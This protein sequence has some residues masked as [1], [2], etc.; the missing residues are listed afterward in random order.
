MPLLPLESIQ[1]AAQHMREYHFRT[2]LSETL[3]LEG[4]LDFNQNRQ[5]VEIALGGGTLPRAQIYWLNRKG[6]GRKFGH[7][8]WIDLPGDPYPDFYSQVLDILLQIGEIEAQQEGDFWLVRLENLGIPVLQDP[9][10]VWERITASA[11]QI[12][13]EK[14]VERSVDILSHMEMHLEVLIS[15]ESHMIQRIIFDLHGPDLHKRLATTFGASEGL[16][17]HPRRDKKKM[18]PGDFRASMLLMDIPDIGGWSEATHSLW[19]QK[20]INLIENND[21]EGIY[22]EIYNKHF[23]TDE[24]K[25]GDTFDH[26]RHHPLV[27]GTIYE[28][29]TGP[30]PPFY[31]IWFGRDAHFLAN[32]NYYW[33]YT[34]YGR[35]YNHF[36]GEDLGLEHQWYFVFDSDSPDT[37]MPGDRYYSARDWAFG[38]PPSS[39]DPRPNGLNFREAIN[40]YSLEDPFAA[41]RAWLIMGHVLHLLQDQGQPDHAMLVAHP[42]SSKSE[43]DAYKKYHY[44]EILAV[45]AAAAACAACSL[46]CLGCMAGVG[47]SVEAGCWASASDTEWG[48]EKLIAEEGY[49][50][51][52]EPLR[53]S[54]V[55]RY[56]NF[57]A[58]FKAVADYAIQAHTDSGL[59]SAL[60]CGWLA[61]LPPIPNADPDIDSEDDTETAPYLALTD[62]VAVNTISTCAGFL[63]EFCEII[64]RPPIVERVAVMQWEPRATPEEFAAFPGAQDYCLFYEAHWE[65]AGKKRTLQTGKNHPLSL[66]RPAY[67]FVMFS[68]GWKN[69]HGGRRMREV[70]LNLKGIYPGT[71]QVMDHEVELTE[72]KDSNLGFFYWGS[73]EPFNCSKEEYSLQMVFEGRDQGGHLMR[74]VHP[75]D[76]LDSDPSTIAYPH[77]QIFPDH[78][79]MNYS[80]GSDRNHLIKISPPELTEG[81]SPAGQMVLK[82]EPQLH[83]GRPGEDPVHPVRAEVTLSLAQKMWDCHQEHYMGPPMC[84]ITW[85]LASQI[86]KVSRIS[87]QIGPPTQFGLKLEL[88][89]IVKGVKLSAR[90]AENK[91]AAFGTYR[92]RVN[93]E[94]GDSPNGVTG[95]FEVTLK[96]V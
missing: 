48:Y 36:G 83:P 94:F 24:F 31:T 90:S 37:T 63:Q 76:V 34:G 87:P 53:Q 8:K 47:I 89:P 12:V 9:E 49:S 77:S 15:R 19:A 33:N 5:Y 11:G 66:D 75:G 71:G 56:P 58:Y 73:F 14:V 6:L 4:E 22:A 68:P 23:M 17:E 39:N 26:T 7:D 78:P 29:A 50:P 79:L 16:P 2:E 41:H 70:S 92:I 93:Y 54:Q 67:I 96:V 28:D 55:Q 42:G 59:E 91:T 30:M 82:V 69:L 72:A 46:F 85:K 86:L 95:Q 18:L 81:Q 80:P 61:L 1:T 38:P 88:Q 32:L 64:N 60:G 44:C 52:D 20:A 3:V 27:A 13:P 62:R 10:G 21:T 40:Q 84:D 57:N 35:Y 74:R 45:E 51:A 25:A 43:P 65:Q